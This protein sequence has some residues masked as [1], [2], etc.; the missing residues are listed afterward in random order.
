[1]KKLITNTHFK[2]KSVVQDLNSE[3]GELKK[4]SV[5]FDNSNFLIT[6]YSPLSLSVHMIVEDN[7][8]NE[9]HIEDCNCGYGGTG[10]NTTV[11]F[12]K[13]L[14][15]K[16]DVDEI[17]SLVFN[18]DAL[19]FDV[20]NYEIQLQSIDN[21]FCFFPQVRNYENLIPLDGNV[22]TD[23]TQGQVIFINPQYHYFFGFL[24]FI[25]KVNISTF[26]FHIG[27]N[28]PLGNYLNIDSLRDTNFNTEIPDLYGIEHVNLSLK[29][30]KLE[31]LCLIDRQ[32]EIQTINSIY[33]SLTNQ[34]LFSSEKYDLNIKKKNRF[35]ILL[36]ELFYKEKEKKFIISD[37]IVLELEDNK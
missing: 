23:I 1:M 25:N 32:S 20:E 2:E 4:V 9:L 18:N 34:N 27:N 30:D 19:Q 17:K 26:E 14:G 28:S 3:F 22:F 35:K 11:R 21:S 15:L 5:F 29:S 24:N 6:K 10:P 37:K 16:N 8:N 13:A 7:Y 36:E 31:I 33:L 12:L